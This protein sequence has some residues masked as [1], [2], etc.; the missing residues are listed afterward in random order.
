MDETRD[1][2]NGANLDRRKFLGALAGAAATGALLQRGGGAAKAQGPTAYYYEDSFGNILPCS[3][4]TIAA[5]ILPPP[6]PGQGANPQDVRR[7]VHPHRGSHRLPHPDDSPDSGSGCS[8]DPC[9]AGTT[10]V[11]A[12]NRMN[13]LMI[14]VDQMR[15]PRWVPSSQSLATLLPNITQLQNMSFVFSN[16]FVAATACSPSRATLLTGLYSQQTCMF[17]TEDPGSPYPPS[18]Q[19]WVQN[20]QEWQ[21]FPTI[22]GVLSQPPLGYQTAWIGKWHL[23]ANP[24]EGT[25][26]PCNPGGNGPSDYGFN[27][28]YNVPTPATGSRYPNYYPSPNGGMPNEGSFGDFL[29]T[30]TVPSIGDVPSG[31]TNY[32]ALTAP[33]TYD[34]LNDAAIYQAFNEWLTNLEGQTPPYPNWFTAV[35]FVNPHDISGFPYTFWP[36]LPDQSDFTAPMHPGSEGYQPPPVASAP[37]TCYSVKGTGE[38]TTIPPIPASPNTPIYSA[39]AAPENYYGAS[40]NYNDS[41]TAYSANGKPDLQSY[42]Q[43]SNANVVG[44][45]SKV[46]GWYNFLNYYFWMQQC[47]DDQIGQVL[48]ALQNSPFW[49]NTV[50]IF[51]SDHGDYGGSHWLKGKTGALYDEVINVPLYIS[52]PTFSTP[53]R[54]TQAVPRAFVCSSVDILPLVY[55]LALG[56]DS[57]RCNGNDIINYLNGR[58]SIRDAIYVGTSAQQRRLSSFTNAY[59]PGTASWQQYQPFVLVTTDE[60][61]NVTSLPSHAVA[62]RTVDPTIKDCNTSP[63][64]NTGPFGGGKLGVYSYWQANSTKPDTTQPQQFEF[65]N[66]EP[67]APGDDTLTVNLGETG[68]QYFQSNDAGGAATLYIDNFNL[69][70]VQSEFNLVPTVLSTAHTNALNLWLQFAGGNGCP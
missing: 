65:Y 16:Y 17:V 41:P 5:G 52:M 58:E 57:W 46:Q 70:A 43:K 20:S 1:Q 63:C 50:I 42:Y 31:G 60:Y 13:I 36:T 68:N 14:M 59:P 4:D 39:S 53:P 22:G 24:L 48:N 15:A 3:P 51:L 67:T 40:W 11:T 33:T 9:P 55:S 10:C 30:T 12:P 34:Q 32:P 8:G 62:F 54:Q 6:I 28:Q 7:P 37:T 26:A 47:V 35:S 64:D 19:P 27:S 38:S 21:G 45:V 56:N 29:G 66:Y 61:Y 49:A 44:G 2:Q 23:S 25:L 69:T 18:L